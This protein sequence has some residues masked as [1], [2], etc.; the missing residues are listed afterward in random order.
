MRNRWL[1]MCL[2][3]GLD[4]GIFAG[5]GCGSGG[6]TGGETISSQPLA[7]KIGGAAWSVMTAQT[8]SFL[9]D[10]STFFV[11]LYPSAFTACEAFAAPTDVSTMIMVIPK[12]A[13][14]YGVSLA[15]PATATFSIPPSENKIASS[16][17]VVI[18]S[19]TATTI[20]GGANISFDGNNMVDGQFTATICP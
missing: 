1:A 12:T 9:S 16:G 3:A 15:G 13:G 7:G 8:D 19:V 20:T 6:S 18:D 5:A 14:S 2:G 11:T 4:A 10:A 17:R